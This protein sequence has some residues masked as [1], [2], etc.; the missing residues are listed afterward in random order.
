ME[1]PTENAGHTHFHVIRHT[2]IFN[3]PGH[4]APLSPT[5]KGTGVLK[6]CHASV[7]STLKC[8]EST[9]CD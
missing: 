9:T 8:F 7:G 5:S 2:A 1:C 3:R 4:R 6:V